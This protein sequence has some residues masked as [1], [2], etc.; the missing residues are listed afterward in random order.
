MIYEDS[1]FMLMVKENEN[2]MED[3][4]EDGKIIVAHEDNVKTFYNKFKYQKCSCCGMPLHN[5]G[6][7]IGLCKNCDYNYGTKECKHYRIKE[8]K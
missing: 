5:L 1:D 7:D 4:V 2:K 6:N 3:Y 8:L